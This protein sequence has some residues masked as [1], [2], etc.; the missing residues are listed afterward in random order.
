MSTPSVYT[1]YS[2]YASSELHTN[3]SSKINT[4]ETTHVATDNGES[5]SDINQSQFFHD[6]IDESSG[7][8]PNA[9]T[10]PPASAS[11]HAHPLFPNG[12]R[13]VAIIPAPTGSAPQIRRC[14]RNVTHTV[15]RLIKGRSHTQAFYF[16]HNLIGVPG[17]QYRKGMQIMV[18]GKVGVLQDVWGLENGFVQF[19]YERDAMPTV[20]VQVQ[21]EHTQLPLQWKVRLAVRR[22]RDWLKGYWLGTKR[23][24]SRRFPFNIF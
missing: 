5:L 11:L 17:E 9:R 19:I 2:V 16:L 7:H 6:S 18:D 15:R 22:R 14:L 1:S 21:I 24:W 10:Y 4:S 8:S 23:V 20:L 12:D 13:H 3:N